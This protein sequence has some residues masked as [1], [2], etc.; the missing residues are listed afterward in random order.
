M[1]HEEGS[2]SNNLMSGIDSKM[3]S[4]NKNPLHQHISQV[5][6][7]QTLGNRNLLNYQFQN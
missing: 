3:E 7:G 5:A 6:I 2:I 1:K 4:R